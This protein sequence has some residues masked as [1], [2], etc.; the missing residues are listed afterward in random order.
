MYDSSNLE[1]VSIVSSITNCRLTAS[2]G[3]F[4]CWN[5]DIPVPWKEKWGMVE[6]GLLSMSSTPAVVKI[7][8]FSTH[9][10]IASSLIKTTYSIAQ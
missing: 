3:L 5:E 1:V 6:D 8:L 2:V 10:H 9:G 7:P 4:W